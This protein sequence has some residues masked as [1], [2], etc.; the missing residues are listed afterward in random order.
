MRQ[1]TTWSSPVLGCE[2]AEVGFSLWFKFSSLLLVSTF[3]L[4]QQLCRAHPSHD[5][6]QQSERP[7][8]TTQA[9]SRSLVTSSSLKFHRPK[10]VVKPKD[11]GAKRDT[12]P[13]QHAGRSVARN[14]G[15]DASSTKDWINSYYRNGNTSYLFPYPSSLKHCLLGIDPTLAS[16]YWINANIRGKRRHRFYFLQCFFLPHLVSLFQKYP[17][18]FSSFTLTLVLQPWGKE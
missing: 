1:P 8:Q 12:L 16:A 2:S 4:D 7:S 5:G 14:E 9:P 6:P 10:Q 18:A 13:T 15:K 17:R 11:Y 3:S